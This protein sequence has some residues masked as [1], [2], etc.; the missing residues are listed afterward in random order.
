MKI[1]WLGQAGLMFETSGKIIIC[2][3]YLSDSC[4]KINPKSKRRVPVCESFL[5]IK[6]D[7]ILLTH[8][9]LDH[10]DPETLRHY[11]NS[12]KKMLILASGNAWTKAR[13]LGGGHNYVEFNRHTRWSEGEIV[14]KAVK[15]QHSDH[16]AIG[17]IIE[18]EGK[19]YYIT[20]DTLCCEDIFADLPSDIDVCFVPVN[21]VGNNMNFSDA[22]YFCNRI[23]AKAV[24]LHC[25]LFDD[26]DMN[27]FPYENKVVPQ[28][29]KEIEL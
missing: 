21:G 23:N 3:P 20:G 8:D 10:T 6:P 28:F 1:T 2:D 26:I 12:D 25:G 19:K 14:F 22:A 9:H 29:Y 13:E 24:P 4:A 7:I 15:A 16:S 11:I 27:E 5:K 18:A 17:I